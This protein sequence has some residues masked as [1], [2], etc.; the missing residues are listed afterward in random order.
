MSR[1]RPPSAS[2]TSISTRTAAAC[3]LGAAI[4]MMAVLSP[5]LARAA[6][7]PADS[8]A[9]LP[10]VLNVSLLLSAQVDRLSPGLAGLGTSVDTQGP[11]GGAELDFNVVEFHVPRETAFGS[12]H[13]YGR[14]LYSHRTL[15]QD[16]TS[17]VSGATGQEI[18]SDARC[19]ELMGG[20]RVGFPVISRGSL[21]ISRVYLKYEANSIFSKDTDSDLL[22][23]TTY[24]VGFERSSGPLQGSFFELG[25]G[26]NGVFGSTYEKKRWK[27]HTMVQTLLTRG[28]PAKRNRGTLTGYGELYLDSDNKSG[29]DALR[30]MV[31]LKLNTVGL[32]QAVQGLLGI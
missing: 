21:A 13:V 11:A 28:D 16:T 8:T 25:Y 14:I 9:P 31:G 17:S 1:N 29:P 2:L 6:D 4:I 7:A 32:V 22:N 20:L 10:E 24:A 23:V 5:G 26:Q 19:A 18:I 30:V 12:I 15:M 27:V 3:M